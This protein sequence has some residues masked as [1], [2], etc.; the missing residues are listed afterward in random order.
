MSHDHTLASLGGTVRKLWPNETDKF[1]DHLLRLDAASRR[2]RFAHAVSNAFVADYAS[3]ML[4]NGAIVFGYFDGETLVACAE[5]RRIGVTWGDTAE[6]AF[7]VEASHQDRGIATEL[8]GRI[9]RSARNRSVRHLIMSCLASNAKMQSVARRFE[10]ELSF[11]AGEVIADIVPE[12][13][14]PMSVM[15]EAFEDRV[16]FFRAVFDLGPKAIAAPQAAASYDD[17]ITKMAS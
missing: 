1:R 15:A 16:D 11:E 14:N 17:R 2:M 4:S 10:A 7:S 13:A 9:I 12:A 5:L 3:R 6:A 8:L